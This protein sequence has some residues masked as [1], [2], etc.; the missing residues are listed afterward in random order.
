MVEIP[1]V[2]L[3]MEGVVSGFMGIPR[4]TRRQAAE[5]F[6]KLVGVTKAHSLPGKS[7]LDCR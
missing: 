3:D 6:A 7:V 1:A 2:I 4:D 5:W